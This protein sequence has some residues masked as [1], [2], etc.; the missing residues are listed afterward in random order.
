MRIAIYLIGLI[1]GVAYIAN[2][3]GSDFI[4][5]LAACIVWGSIWTIIY[6][7]VLLGFDVGSKQD[8]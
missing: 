2:R 3:I 8:V 7:L 1:A 5:Y 6:G 4:A